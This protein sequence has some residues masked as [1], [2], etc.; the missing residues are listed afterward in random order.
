MKMKRYG[1][2][3]ALALFMSVGAAGA[4]DLKGTTTNDGSFLPLPAASNGNLS[5]I[6]VG[7]S[8]GMDFANTAINYDDSYSYGETSVPFGAG[9]DGIGS[10]GFIGEGQI[11]YDYQAGKVVFGVFG[12]GNIS[13]TKTELSIYE[14]LDDAKAELTRDWGWYAGA[15]VGYAATKDTLIYVGGGYTQADFSLKSDAFDLD[16]AETFDGYFGE[17][18]VETRLSG[19][20]FGKVFGRYV[21]YNAKEY[22]NGKLA[23]DPS[24]LQ[25]MVGLVVKR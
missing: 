4:T 10:T 14:G 18:G 13:N 11:G 25:A 7:L 6:L 5:G 12:G 23:V 3:T 15:R 8:G 20:V 2:L 16:E 19:I 24:E 1:A 9:L 22:D 17:V 21:D